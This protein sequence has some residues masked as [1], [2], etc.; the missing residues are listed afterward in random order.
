M[1]ST[2]LS[3]DEL[4]PGSLVIGDA[5]E[6]AERTETLHEY[7]ASLDVPLSDDIDSQALRNVIKELNEKMGAENGT[8]M[9][10]PEWLTS[11]RFHGG[12]HG[13]ARADRAKAR[14]A[15]RKKV[16]KNRK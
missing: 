6:S 9:V 12:K 14:I 8:H 2:P 7:L 1:N 15:H 5:A 10:A 16:R 3:S 4:I 11:G 13:A